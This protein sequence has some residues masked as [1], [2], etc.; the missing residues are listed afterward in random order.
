MKR[1]VNKYELISMYIKE[2]DEDEQQSLRI[3]LAHIDEDEFAK[4]T[5]TEVL[6]KGFFILKYKYINN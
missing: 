5:N 1:I 3:Y 6:R 4:L 2:W